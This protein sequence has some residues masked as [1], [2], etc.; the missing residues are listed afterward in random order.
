MYVCVYAC[1]SVCVCTYAKRFWCTFRTCEV[2]SEGGT[3][4]WPWVWPLTWRRHQG[5]ISHKGS[6][7]WN[8]IL[9]QTLSVGQAI[10][11]CFYFSIE[12]LGR[13]GLPTWVK[14]ILHKVESVRTSCLKPTCRRAF[15]SNLIVFLF[16]CVFPGGMNFLTI[17]GCSGCHLSL[18]F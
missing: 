1:A 11:K 16:Y 12:R 9:Q 7:S 3:N 17:T 2:D 10:E 8:C 13:L 18:H 15:I 14:F 5:G 4:T 6:V